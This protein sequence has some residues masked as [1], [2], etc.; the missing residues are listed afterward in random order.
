M[1]MGRRLLHGLGGLSWRVV[2]SVCSTCRVGSGTDSG[3][4]RMLDPST[5]VKKVAAVRRV[6][7]IGFCR[8]QNNADGIVFV[9]MRLCYL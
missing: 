4:L 5:P 9:F 8:N 7:L 6:K 1:G 2:K 3:E